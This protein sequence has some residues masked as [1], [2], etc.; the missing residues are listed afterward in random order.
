MPR[1]IDQDLQAR[2]TD[3]RYRKGHVGAEVKSMWVYEPTPQ[4]LVNLLL[5]RTA[6]RLSGHTLGTESMISS[7]APLMCRIMRKTRQSGP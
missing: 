6:A 4:S 3:S 1:R 7:I 2:G 5:G